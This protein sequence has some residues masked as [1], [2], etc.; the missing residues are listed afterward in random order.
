MFLKIAVVVALL[1][2]AFAIAYYFG[3]ALPAIERSKFAF[4]K[5]KYD[6]E[7]KQKAEAKEQTETQRR[8]DTQVNQTR[9]GYCR[10]DAD[11][12]YWNYVKLNGQ[13][14]PGKPAGT[15]NAP[16]SV[17]TYADKKKNETLAE[18]HRLYH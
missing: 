16:I 6:T 13:P 17:W 4:E 14:A 1:I 10:A 5:E 9:F 11:K 12:E 18:C 2:P 3:F 8:L 15:Y 7:Q